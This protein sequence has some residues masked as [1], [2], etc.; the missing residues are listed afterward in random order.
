LR[1]EKERTCWKPRVK[2]YCSGKGL[3]VALQDGLFIMLFLC[4]IVTKNTHLNTLYFNLSL[5][6]TF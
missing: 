6:Y 2:I 5:L 3:A 4:F 1:E